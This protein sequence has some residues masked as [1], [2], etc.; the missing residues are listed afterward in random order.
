MLPS[1]CRHSRAALGLTGKSTVQPKKYRPCPFETYPP[2]PVLFTM[3]SV[4]FPKS[5]F[6]ELA[7]NLP[8]HMAER[9]NRSRCHLKERRSGFV[10]GSLEL[11]FFSWSP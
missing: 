9:E 6:S 8:R 1:F 7:A 10:H 2:S 11:L 5:I 3:T 4:A